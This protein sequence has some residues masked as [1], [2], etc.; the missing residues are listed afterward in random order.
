M[1]CAAG[2]HSASGR[3]REVDEKMMPMPPDESQ[4]AVDPPTPTSI[5]DAAL[6]LAVD[7]AIAEVVP[8]LLEGGVQVILLKG[9]SHARWLYDDPD[10]RTYTDCDLLVPPDEAVRA[11]N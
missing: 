10:Q 2:D 3:G 9:P 6:S 4:L 7:R 8:R 1:L 11:S 5:R